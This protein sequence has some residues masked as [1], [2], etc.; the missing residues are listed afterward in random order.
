MQMSLNDI[1][2]SCVLASLMCRIAHRRQNQA[3][4][5]YLNPWNA[6]LHVLNGIDAL[7]HTATAM[8]MLRVAYETL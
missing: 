4:V 3:R 7:V 1:P 5:R 8:M 2:N 6:F